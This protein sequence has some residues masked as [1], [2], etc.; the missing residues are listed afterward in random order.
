[1]PTTFD[2]MD[3]GFGIELECYLPEGA[4]QQQAAAAVAHRL[5]LPCYVESYNHQVRNHWK[6]V[7]DGSLG[8]IDRGIEFVSPILRGED[9]LAQIEKVCR[10]LTDFGCTVSKK[11]GLHVH[12]GVI[13]NPAIDFFK[14]IVR[15]YSVFEPVLDSMLPASRRGSA[16]TYCRSMTSASAA[17][18]A[19]ARDFQT[20][21]QVATASAPSSNHSRYFKLNL[22]AYARH[23]TIEFRQHS[24]TLDA[25]KARRWTVLCLRMIA[26][27]RGTLSLAA[28]TVRANLARPGTKSHAI[29]ELMM[30][31][32]G[33]TTLEVLQLTGWPS[34]SM[35][36]Q[37]RICGLEF[38]AQR[39]GRIVRYFAQ[40]SA[41]AQSVPVTVDGLGATDDER[42]YMR[43]RISDLGGPVA[44][45]A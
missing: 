36:A 11:C 39:T 7:T 18:I 40:V 24:G 42:S 16:N 8:D 31:P 21:R 35:P 23:R 28:P 13:G 2:H 37:A 14:N 20:L 15:L 45:A 26:T 5:G 12:V 4:T 29:G 44:W 25:N 30:R 10:A 41:P 6:V 33:V 9:G 32:Q 38:T 17:A 27:A 34:V 3:A 19:A 43:Q 1:M 22:E